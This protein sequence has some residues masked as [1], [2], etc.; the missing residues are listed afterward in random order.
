MWS[1]CVISVESPVAAA[2]LKYSTLSMFL[3][4]LFNKNLK[5]NLVVLCPD[6]SFVQPIIFVHTYKCKMGGTVVQWSALSA[7]H[8]KK[9][10]GLKMD[11]K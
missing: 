7:P 3:F 6:M 2:H 1:D 8:S 11:V 10:H 9:V 4:Q 5:K